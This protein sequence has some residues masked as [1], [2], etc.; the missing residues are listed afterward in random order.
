M[1]YVIL[2][3]FLGGILILSNFYSAHSSSI[4]NCKLSITAGTGVCKDPNCNCIR[5]DGAVPSPNDNDPKRS[6]G[7]RYSDH[8][9][10]YE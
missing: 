10:R 5:Y 7:H 4:H 8:Y 3:L 6:C 2:T 9:T 1:R